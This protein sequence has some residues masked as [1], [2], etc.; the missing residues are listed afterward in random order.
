MAQPK[1]STNKKRYF[2]LESVANDASK[3]IP[4]L[5]NGG[6]KLNEFKKIAEQ[7]WCYNQA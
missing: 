4:L 2:L 6:K 5:E 1:N 7:V 3:L